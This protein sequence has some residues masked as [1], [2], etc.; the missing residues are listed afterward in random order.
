VLETRNQVILR[1]G[2]S[3]KV[4]SAHFYGQAKHPFCSP[5]CTK[6]TFVESVSGCYK[7][8]QHKP[9]PYRAADADTHFTGT[10]EEINERIRL[11]FMRVIVT[12]HILFQHAGQKRRS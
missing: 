4:L 11:M 3:G 1:R 7:L 12:T 6:Y 8:V 10:P 9:L 5:P 2:R